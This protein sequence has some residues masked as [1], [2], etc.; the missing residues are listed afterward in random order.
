MRN[1]KNNNK[2]LILASVISLVFLLGWQYFY[3]APRQQQLLEQQSKDDKPK[4]LENQEENYTNNQKQI[5]VPKKDVTTFVPVNLALKTE[6]RVYFENSKVKGSINPVGLKIDNLSLKF[7]KTEGIETALL[8]PSETKEA[9]FVQ[10]GFASENEIKMP[11]NKTIWSIENL[12]QNNFKAFWKN[13]QGFTFVVNFKLDENYMFDITSSVINNSNFDAEISPFVRILRTQ[14]L[15]EEATMIS[16]EGFVYNLGKVFS[17][18]EYGKIKDKKRLNYKKEIE[19]F[20]GGFTDKYWLTSFFYNNVICF[21][22]GCKINSSDVSVNHFTEMGVDRYQIDFIANDV[23]L[24]QKQAFSMPFKFFAGA[25]ELKLLDDYKKQGFTLEGKKYEFTNFDKTVDFGIFYFLTK[26]IFLLLTFL[27]SFLHNFGFAI[28]LLTI[29]VKAILFPIA[30]K[31]YISMGKMK[32]LAPEIK[33]IRENSKDKLEQNRKI[34]ELYKEK[35]VNPLSGCLPIMLQIPVFFALYKVLY[36]SLEMRGAE[37][38]W[39]IKDLSAKDPTSIFNLFGLLPFGV[40]SFLQIGVLPILMGITT[41]LQQSLS[42][43]SNDP[44]QDM[45]IKTMPFLLIFIFAGFPAGIV[46]YWVVN[47]ILSMSQQLY[48]EKIVVPKK[49]GK[50]KALKA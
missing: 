27:N 37:F 22:S 21:E 20:W 47:N 7:Y 45:I 28:I 14:P 12:G 48:I 13:E 10:F 31:S 26:P 40:P 36:I 1:I 38:I 18:I 30:T 46:L 33:E 34:M 23:K 2:N 44:T 49:L 15:K 6:N 19:L 3:E 9:Y 4:I 35:Q 8:F 43:R 42:P 17:E 39:W 11:N 29:I 32:A 5:D 41:Y 25:K 24:P 16:H 50:K